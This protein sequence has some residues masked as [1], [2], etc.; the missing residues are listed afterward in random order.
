MGR[1]KV[2][3]KRVK[4]HA[5]SASRHFP[6]SLRGAVIVGL[7]AGGILTC[8]ASAWSLDLL[9]SR[10]DRFLQGKGGLPV[11]AAESRSEGEGGSP[12]RAVDQLS[13]RPGS[14]S[15]ALPRPD[16][17]SADSWISSS[18]D[19]LV[20]DSQ[21]ERKQGNHPPL[22]VVLCKNFVGYANNIITE[23]QDSNDI[24]RSELCESKCRESPSCNCWSWKDDGF[25]RI[26]RAR[27]RCT[28]SG[29][30][31]NAHWK[32]GACSR[33]ESVPT[34]K[35]QTEVF[36]GSRDVHMFYYTWYRAQAADGFWGHW[37]GEFTPQLKARNHRLNPDKNEICSAFRPQ[38]GPYS[39]KDKNVVRTHMVQMRSASV[40]VVV[41]AWSPKTA[42][43]FF[44]RLLEEA[45]SAG[46][47]VAILLQA[48][49]GR[50]T[51][52]VREDIKH[53]QTVQGSAALHRRPGRYSE[54]RMKLPVI[55]VSEPRLTSSADW[56]QLL[57][58]GPMS[59][60]GKEFDAVL[61]SCWFDKE[62]EALLDAGFDGAFSDP[63]AN[64]ASY[65]STARNWPRMA[66]SAMK[67]GA[68]FI[69]SVAPGFNAIK[70]D[71]TT[72]IA[73][74]EGGNYFSKMF[75]AA[76]LVSP[77][78]I[79]IS[80]WNQWHEGTQV[81]PAVP[82]E[83]Y[84]DYGSDGPNAYVD[85]SYSYVARWLASREPAKRVARDIIPVLI[86][87][88]ERPE[89]LR[90]T[91]ASILQH[92]SDM[93]MFP[94]WASQDG[95]HAGVTQMLE[96]HKNQKSLDRH[97]RFPGQR[98]KTGYHRL[99]EHY[100]WA[101]D[102]VFDEGY[103]QLIILEDDLELSPDFFTYMQA[104][105]PLLRAD[106]RLI[107]VS[108]WNDNGKPELASDKTALVRT[109]FFPGLG[110]M[111]LRGFWNEVKSKWPEAYW[112][113]FLRHSDVRRSR[114]CIRPEVSRTHTFGEKGTSRSQFYHQHLKV[115]T[116]N[117]DRVD[118]ASADLD[119]VATSLNFDRY[120]SAQILS[121]ELISLGELKKMGQD[122]R[123]YPR[124]AIFCNDH[125]YLACARFFSLMEDQ[126]DGVRRGA[127]R[128]VI[129]LSWN[130]I[131]AFV[132]KDW[133]FV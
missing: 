110:W 13:S 129:P 79:C 100:K 39:S 51:A 45:A 48:Y 53:I 88:Y 10:S 74:R 28:W 78:V 77:T 125:D 3:K 7:I 92:R 75:S 12:W 109:D 106:P 108:A 73:P 16:N 126:K 115:N 101:L 20:S 118:W 50:T 30:P 112:D 33:D 37:D 128:G 40:G 4:A 63:A 65:G 1:A 82:A 31:D 22:P 131:R 41:I 8:I 9:V 55:Y 95:D 122:A 119:Y 68:L 93:R 43:Q 60:R 132:V 85:L 120:L 89:Y 117:K 11:S 86:I 70:Y 24:I 103:E 57:V 104:T 111:L 90:Q 98:R 72:I 49:Q 38:L 76:S 6:E 83:N 105:L 99:A 133:P 58:P 97:L 62:D 69:P 116:L 96:E 26:G 44:G 23:E 61:L 21:S 35:D 80:S 113:D 29:S 56:S 34:G 81:E 114:Q 84:E 47:E 127:Y 107:C 52:T 5:R 121:A 2:G 14:A 66:E 67:R 91:L 94:L 54:S 15:A 124:L 25:C 87:A 18:V 59:I 64:G 102:K 42:R 130:G 71:P 123:K 17:D 27:T 19:G 46:L 36:P 32:Y